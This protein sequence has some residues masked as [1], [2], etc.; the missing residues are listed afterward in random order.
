MAR[1][2]GGGPGL[3]ERVRL[4]GP[5]VEALGVA[6]LER[7]GAELRRR[8]VDL[9]IGDRRVGVLVHE[10]VADAAGGA[11]PEP[12]PAVGGAGCSPMTRCGSPRGPR[13]L[14]RR[15]G[16]GVASVASRSA[17]P[18]VVPASGAR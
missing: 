4:A 8:V 15:V 2:L 1:D 3:R 12:P 5:E 7:L 11:P 18:G 9:G 10:A 17:W 6:G 16:R 13:Q 14:T